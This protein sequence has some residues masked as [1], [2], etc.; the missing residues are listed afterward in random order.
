MKRLLAAA[1]ALALLAGCSTAPY[2]VDHTYSS[3]SQSSR[4]KFI[5]LHYTVGNTATSLHELTQEVV[6]SHYLLTD[7]DPPVLYGLVDES[8]QANHAGVSAWKRYSLLNPSSI[9]I[10]IVNRG[11]IDTPQG[12]QWFPFPQRQMD[13]L[14]PLLKDI[15][16]RHHIAPENILGHADI[17]PQRKQDP[18]PLFPWKQL[19]DA[20][21]IPWPDA[22]QVAA[23]RARYDQAPPDV[24]WFQQR[25]AAYGYVV[26]QTGV[27]DEATAA[28]LSTFQMKY[29]PA[30]IDGQPDAETAAIL[31]VMTPHAAAAVPA[32]GGAGGDEPAQEPAGTPETP[33][34]PTDATPDVP[35]DEPPVAP[36]RLPAATAQ[37]DPGARPSAGGAPGPVPVA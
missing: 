31:E 27:L 18:G 37:P 6:S 35:P 20:G 25:L 2:K 12:R 4:V 14:I 17:A 1:L 22:Y 16:A 10:E 24:A 36:A 5:V 7:G 32:P 33:A 23:R 3:K 21:L 26:P 30:N 28:V 11:F 9:G 19:A 8:R 29:R 13:V 34:T 15:V